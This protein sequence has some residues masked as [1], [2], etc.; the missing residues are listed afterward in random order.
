MRYRY[1]WTTHPTW[2]LARGWVMQAHWWHPYYQAWLV[3]R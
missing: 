3:R 1:R 2:Y